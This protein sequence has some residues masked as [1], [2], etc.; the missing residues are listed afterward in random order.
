[1]I[2][3]APAGI[4]AAHSARMKVIGIAGTFPA[5][6]LRKAE[7]VVERLADLALR[8]ERDWLIVDVNLD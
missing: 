2:E 6:R 1:V 3:D 8:R 4:E 7:A 5:T